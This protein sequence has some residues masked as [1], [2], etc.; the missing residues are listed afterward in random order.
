MLEE[1]LR[2]VAMA[3]GSRREKANSP[4]FGPPPFT[5]SR[6]GY[7]GGGGDMGHGAAA[8]VEGGV[9]CGAHRSSAPVTM[10]SSGPIS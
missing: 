9:C 6:D 7:N 4:A 3:R 5:C 8:G 1:P 2:R 10:G